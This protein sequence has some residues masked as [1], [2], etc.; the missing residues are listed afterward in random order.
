LLA[1]SHPSGRGRSGRIGSFQ[2]GSQTSDRGRQK[3]CFGRQISAA[4]LGNFSKEQNGR[5]EITIQ[6]EK[7]IIDANRRS[8]QH[9]F[10]YWDQYFGQWKQ[11]CVHQKR[12]AEFGDDEV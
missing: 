8:P 4:H 12:L 10:P 5:G 3:D 1:S 6:I 2:K 7:V 11:L 9:A